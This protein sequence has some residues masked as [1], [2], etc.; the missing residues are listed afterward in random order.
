M[1][2]YYS[3]V[4]WSTNSC[5][6]RFPKKK[7][8]EVV[9]VI[10]LKQELLQ[11]LD[12]FHFTLSEES[13]K[14]DVPILKCCHNHLPLLVQIFFIISACIYITSN[15]WLKLSNQQISYWNRKKK[16]KVL[17]TTSRSSFHKVDVIIEVV[18]C[19]LQFIQGK[20]H[21]CWVLLP[22]CF[23]FIKSYSIIWWGY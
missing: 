2:L 17:V 5:C 10:C 11:Y 15:I 6:C 7:K 9:V 4:N 23:L 13:S 14:A 21:P 22:P 8:Q 18:C 20:D 19:C 12:Q 1:F 16:L 3:I